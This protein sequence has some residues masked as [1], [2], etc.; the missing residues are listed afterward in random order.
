MRATTRS[1]PYVSRATRA[2]RMFELSPL[3]TAA[4]ANASSMPAATSVSRSKPTPTMRRPRNELGRRRKADSSRSTMATLWPVSSS[5]RAADDAAWAAG[6]VA[7]AVDVQP[8]G[9]SFD[10]L[11]GLVRP[12]YA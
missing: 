4:K 11:Q 12:R 9:N 2:E 5:V 1:T 8:D 7:G 3:E 10:M 6:G